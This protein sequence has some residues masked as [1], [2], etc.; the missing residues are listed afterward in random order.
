[1]YNWRD[2]RDLFITLGFFCGFIGIGMIYSFAVQGEVSSLL[3]IGLIISLIYALFYVA[4]FGKLIF[5]LETNM[6][7]I[8][9]FIFYIPIYTTIG[10]ISDISKIVSI[11]NIDSSSFI[12]RYFSKYHELYVIHFEVWLFRNTDNKVSQYKFLT[13]RTS[14]PRIHQQDLNAISILGAGLMEYFQNLEIPI[15][16]E[17][18]PQV[19]DSEEIAGN[20]R[21]K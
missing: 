4:S 5:N 2:H 17:M 20:E 1:V 7:S 8:Q 12:A 21:D 10:K 19:F 6:W 16:F 11:E 15:E 13:Q 14:N 9:K 18:N 3:W